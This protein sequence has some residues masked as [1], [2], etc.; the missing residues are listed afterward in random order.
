MVVEDVREATG[1]LTDNGYDVTRLT[2]AEVMS[3]GG[4]EIVGR[5]ITGEFGLLWCQTRAVWFVRPPNKR[6]GVL[7]KRIGSWIKRVAATK[8][9]IVV[10]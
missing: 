4:D 8:M 5:L 9:P 1:V 10:S 3:T 6:A 2:Y 7:Y